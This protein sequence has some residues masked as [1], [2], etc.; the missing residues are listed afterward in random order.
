MTDQP[1]L[2]RGDQLGSFEFSVIRRVSR[3]GEDVS[4]LGEHCEYSM[5]STDEETAGDLETALSEG[6]QSES[7][8]ASL[9][10]ALRGLGNNEQEQTLRVEVRGVAYNTVERWQHQSRTDWK[11][12]RM[13]APTGQTSARRGANPN[14]TYADFIAFQ[15]ETRDQIE[16]AERDLRETAREDRKELL[17][18]IGAGNAELKADLSRDIIRVESRVEALAN[19][20]DD[21]DRQI[22]RM[23]S[24]ATSLVGAALF[25]ATVA[26]VIA[27]FR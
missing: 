20:T 2:R 4:L 27:A 19:K 13:T 14:P 11:N 15:R 8:R 5:F 24:I 3:R 21:N 6:L 9:L 12:P 18:A 16:R 23:Q 26:G 7:S 22:L 1:I 10:G 25:V 17:D